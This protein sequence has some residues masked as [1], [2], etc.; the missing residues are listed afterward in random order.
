LLEVSIDGA[1]GILFN[2]IGGNDLSMHEIN[3]AA[4]TY[5]QCSDPD[6]NIIFGAT[7][8]PDLEGELIYLPL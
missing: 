1:R 4:E 8:S 6:A 5:H 3:T 7:I 2:V